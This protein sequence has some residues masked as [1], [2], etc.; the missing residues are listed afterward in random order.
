MKT[1]LHKIV[2]R[3]SNL[4]IYVMI[5]CQS[6]NMALAT[7]SEAQRRYLEEIGIELQA[8]TQSRSLE[9]V[10]REIESKTDF[11]FAYS[12]KEIKGKQ[13]SLAGGQWYM[14]EVL[15]S[16][17]TQARVSFKRVNESIGLA[18]AKNTQE[19][20]DVI[21]K[22]AVQRA[23]SGSVT[24]ENGEGLPGATVVEKGTTNGTITDIDGN[25]KLEVPDDAVLVVS[26]VGYESQEVSI[27]GLSEINVTLVLDVQGLQEVVVIGYQTVQKKDLTGSTAI[28]SPDASNRVTANSLAESIQGLAPGV[29]VRNGGAPGQDAVIE[30]RG[31][32]S[33]A[34]ASPLYVIDGMLADANPTI[35]TNDIE[36]I[37]ILKDGSAAAIYGSR[38]ANGVVIITTKSGKEGPMRV[39]FNAKTGVQRIPKRW[40]V[41]NNVEFAALQ[42]TQY[43]NSGLPVPALVGDD[44]DPAVNIDWQDEMM[45]VGKMQDYN[46]SLSGGSRSGSYMMSGSYFD[47]TG[48][49]KGRSFERYSFRMNSRSEIGRVTFGE[50]IV[51][52][53]SISDTPGEGNPFY[54]MPQLL[55]VIPV[56]GE[57][58]ISDANPKGYGIGSVN[59]PTYAWNPVA[60]D[61][62]SSQV[63]NYSKLVGNAYINVKITDWISYK[64]NAGLEASFDYLK[65]V[66]KDGVWSFNAAVYPSFVSNVRSTWMSQL[67]EHTLNI[68]KEIGKHALSAVFG[69]SQQSFQREVTEARRSELQ[70]FNDQ[71]LTTINSATGDAAVSGGRLVDNFI[72][73]YLGRIN[74]VYADKYLLTVTGRID[75]NSRFSEDYRTGIFPSVAAGWRLSEESFFD[76]PLI[77]NLKL[78]GSYG[79]LGVIPGSV[80][81]WDYLGTLNSNTRAIFGPG[82]EA[83]VGSY[84][85]RI[86][87]TQLQW[88]TR[89]SQNV[90]IEAGLLGDRILFSAEWYNSLSQDAI[91]QIPLPQYLGNLGGNPFVN[92]GS[93]RNQGFEFSATYRK[94]EGAFKWDASANFTTIKN[95]VEDVGNQGEGIDYLQTGLTRS[96]V[97]RPISEWYLLQTDGLFQNTQDIEDHALEDGTVIQPF[98]Q[99]GDIRFV[100]VN[101]DGQIT[102][103]DRTYSGKSPWPTLQAGGQFNA[104][105]QNFTVNLQLVGVFGNHIYNG[106]KQILDGY[107]NTNFRSDIR[108]W[109]EENPDTD[110]PRI[111]VATNDAALS[112]NASNS[113]R[114]LENG[115][116]LRVRNLEIGYNFADRWFGE[117]GI[118]GARIYL[119]GQ[120]L[121][122]LTKYSG[123]DPDVVGNGIL[124]RGFDAGNWPSSK[125][126][127]LGLQFN[128]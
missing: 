36:S 60:V 115:S 33:F 100:D 51:L 63:S 82:Q 57:D 16:I 88:E 68:N 19:L 107:Q 15:A 97:G 119:S 126:Y 35:N 54:D 103:D 81:S 105:Y 106:V 96:K 38:A 120:N 84:Q 11:K 127:S 108:P 61:E 13:V 9:E 116:Y 7:E 46:L 74:Y 104:S 20:P 29:T 44:F 56:Q 42:R 31:V 128:F 45:R 99:P 80:G 53:H 49:L 93:I 24:D 114:W 23:V 3:M 2:I 92:A 124:E 101:G 37:Q 78:T 1:K 123:L 18:L 111:G 76:V 91:L 10:I 62:L 125:V 30:I 34:D 22:I 77:S 6:L 121:L 117:T 122:T 79:R 94:R 102:E 52:T 86:A 41:M 40:D 28:I 8:S 118:N 47:N 112:Q 21:E 32:G 110:D 12:K 113:D 25:F 50:N 89:I 27:A 17:S 66:R 72:L 70:I 48:V 55:P 4:G 64:F 67:F 85:A 43:E 14:D 75:R 59:A 109:T 73:G 87:N 83:F 39:S 71:Y 90:G 69:V 26:F 98:A 5:V 95:T 58:Y 65:N